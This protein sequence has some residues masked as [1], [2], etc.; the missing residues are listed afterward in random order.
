MGF[1]SEDS[2]LGRFCYRILASP[3][4][5]DC[6]LG[7][8]ISG[9][10]RAPQ[11]L[12]QALNLSTAT[13]DVEFENLL[14]QLNSKEA[15][16]KE[17]VYAIDQYKSS[18]EE[19]LQASNN[20]GQLIKPL[21]DSQID[22]CLESE[23]EHCFPFNN[24]KRFL[25]IIE[26]SRLSLE[27]TFASIPKTVHKKIDDLLSCFEA[28]RA[29]IRARDIA[30]LDY[31]KALDKFDPLSI[32]K[33][34]SALTF[35]QA[36]EY[37]SLGR[38]VDHLKSKYDGFNK[39][40]KTE[41]PYFFKLVTQFMLL[42]LQYI[43]YLQLSL[44]YQLN[45]GCLTLEG[46]MKFDKEDFAASDFIA[47]MI[48]KFERLQPD[49]PPLN[50]ISF[51]KMHLE[52]LVDP[53]YL[54]SGEKSRSNYDPYAK[55][56]SALFNFT[57]QNCGDLGFKKGDVVKVLRSDGEWWEGEMNGKIGVFPSNY[58]KILNI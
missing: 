5:G 6:K 18:L 14:E 8:S 30:L 35:K 15:L 44:Y 25:S 45:T 49:D 27:E 1:I 29:N 40:L 33:H 16:C 20:V 7:L 39:I 51:H 50:I 43:Y 22:G 17:L 2:T 57:P 54:V 46:P 32:K 37:H 11:C 55:Y 21:L 9:A 52:L 41:L 4:D 12:R 28:I 42:M 36:Q 58:V 23:E 10:R 48:L 31:D 47:N 24:C 53:K 38:H 19:L 13:V 3:P 26:D 34:T 56:C